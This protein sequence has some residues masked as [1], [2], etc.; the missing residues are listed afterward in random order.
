MIFKLDPSSGFDDSYFDVRFEVEFE[1]SASGIIKIY[2]DTSGE[3]LDILGAS[4]GRIINGNELITKSSS[5]YG[6]INIFNHDKMNKK[7][8][9]HSK[10]KIRCDV[11]RFDIDG[12]PSKESET[13][14]FYNESKS[15]DAEVIP[16]DLV[17]HNPEVDLYKNEPLQFDI[18][19]GSDKYYELCLRALDE[20]CQ[21]TLEISA[22]RGKTSISVPAEFLYED[23]KL[24]SNVRKNFQFYYVKFQG[25]TYS[26]MANRKY[27]PI[28]KTNVKFNSI[29]GFSPAPQSRIDPTGVE[30]GKDFILSDRYLVLCPREH[31][32]FAAKT[33]YK[34]EK[35]MDLTMLINES[36]NMETVS[37]QIKQFSVND[38]SDKIKNTEQH[39]Q[40][41]RTNVPRP[42]INKNQFQMMQSLSGVYDSISSGRN[43]QS[44]PQASSNTKRQQ[45][46]SFSARSEPKSKPGCLP[47]SR[48]KSTNA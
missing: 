45:V 21:S 12:V 44:P 37:K 2:N 8:K 41:S 16:F 31:S 35:L 48:K 1:V 13:I 26:R 36:Q 42:N 9:A 17:I 30:Y 29:D 47:C 15:L 23:L 39:I 34:P 20:S 7:F 18:I 5:V 19:S 32:A 46:E 25:T 33:E 22:K 4:S 38:D 3:E 27:I 10:V 11:E 43:N 14:E 24:N 28:D 6:H 40:K